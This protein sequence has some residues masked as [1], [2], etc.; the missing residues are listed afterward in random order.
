M[1]L[2]CYFFLK[3]STFACLLKG[4]GKGIH[5]LLEE[6]LIITREMLRE[7]QL[8]YP[9]S[10][11]RDPIFVPYLKLRVSADNPSLHAAPAESKIQNA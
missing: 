5:S 8:A 10:P 4:T 2:L 9:R 11:V 1:S 7:A 6:S 3:Q